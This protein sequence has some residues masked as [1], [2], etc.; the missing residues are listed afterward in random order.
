MFYAP[1]KVPLSDEARA[2][3]DKLVRIAERLVPGGSAS[4]FG[5]WSI[6][7]ADLAF[8]LHRLI[9]NG[10][11]VPPRLR[12]FAAAQWARPSV[13]AFVERERPPFVPYGRGP[14]PAAR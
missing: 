2:A 8:L 12:A 13:R 1:S 7:D 14:I 6:A 11:D 9:L 3:K 5:A 4:L 10:D